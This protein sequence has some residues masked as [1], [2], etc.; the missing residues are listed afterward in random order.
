MTITANDIAKLRASTGAGMM[1]CKKALDEAEGNMDLAAE[2]LRKKGIVKAAKRADKIAAE[3][4][5]YGQALEGNKVGALVEVN[6]ETDFV[7]KSEDFVN[8]V[9]VLAETVAKNN[10]SDLDNLQTLNLASG[11]TVAEALN[12]LTVKIGEKINIRRFERYEGV[13]VGLYL[14]GAKIG[15]LIELEG[16]G[17]NTAN[18]LAMHIAA[19]NPKCLDRTMVSQVDLDKEKE[20]ASAQLREQGKPENIIENILKGKMEK[21]YEENCLVDQIFIKDETLKV[22]DLLVKNGASIKRYVRFELGEGIEKGGC[23]FV[24]EVQAQLK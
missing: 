13:V 24:A 2:I 8:F 7:A 21:Y 18:D 23:D 17:V 1:D 9:K 4:L 3:G 22:K 19:S 16:G 12:T 15:V 20:I 11:E 10:P 5:V 6:S 14:H